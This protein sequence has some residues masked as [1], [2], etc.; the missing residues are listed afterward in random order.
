MKKLLLLTLLLTNIN[1]AK[2]STEQKNAKKEKDDKFIRIGFDEFMKAKSTTGIYV[3]KIYKV[4]G[5][6]HRRSSGTHKFI[7]SKPTDEARKYGYDLNN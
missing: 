7:L 2:T 4:P 3:G 1:H 6:L 5:L